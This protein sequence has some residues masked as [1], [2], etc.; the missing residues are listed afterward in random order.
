MRCRCREKNFNTCE[1]RS[2]PPQ[3]LLRF[4]PSR[5]V[6][7]ENSQNTLKL[8][9]QLPQTNIYRSWYFTISESCSLSNVITSKPTGTKPTEIRK[10]DRV[11]SKEKSSRKGHIHF[12]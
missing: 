3:G 5:L 8:T 2:F 9:S 7:P 10:L 12:L 1:G 6:E 11:S 4:S